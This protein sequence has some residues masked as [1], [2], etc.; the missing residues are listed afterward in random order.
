MLTMKE[1]RDKYPNYN[2]LS[3]EQLADSLHAKHYSDMPKE[4]FYSKIGL[5]ENKSLGSKIIEEV[6]GAYHMPLGR[7]LK[8]IGQGIVDTGEFLT[9][10]AGPMMKFLAK[11]EIPYVSEGAK[12]WPQY[13]ESDV[14]GLGEKQPGDTIFQAASPV[15]TG[16]KGAKLAGKSLEEV[17]KLAFSKG[18]KAANKV[19]DTLPLLKSIAIKPYKKQMKILEEKGLLEG[20]KPNAPDVLE[21]ARIL[22]SPGMKIPHEAVNEA[23]A[24]T[25]EGNYKPWF[26]LQSSIRKEGRR[27]SKM[28]GV[29][30]TLG[31][32]LHSL[33]EKM[34]T[35][36]G[37]AQAARGAPEASEL[38]HQGKLRTAK[39][40]KISP[41][42]K[43]AAGIASAS[44]LPKWMSQ[45][46]RAMGR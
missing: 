23:V 12:H 4:E 24:K 21:A 1:V 26:N 7:S 5:Q 20:Y 29:N 14:F 43:V 22:T 38:M 17:A 6:S 2:D 25:L 35:E 32:K 28:G 18:S 30:N 3:D 45:M 15:G 44:L 13:P 10:P 33:A 36:I 9:N 27:L 37:E 39:Y 41:T 19:G 16:A 31:E 42:S 34:H 11:Q 40:H 8:N 46:L